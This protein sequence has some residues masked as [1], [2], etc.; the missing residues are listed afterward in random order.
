MVNGNVQEFFKVWSVQPSQSFL[1]SLLPWLEERFEAATYMRNPSEEGCILFY[2]CPVMGVISALKYS[3][4]LSL[5]TT[6]L[7]SRPVNGIAVIVHPN[8]ASEGRRIFGSFEALQRVACMSASGMFW[9]QFTV[10]LPCAAQGKRR[11]M[12]PSLTRTMMRKRRKLV[13]WMTQGTM[14]QSF[15]LT[16]GTDSRPI[17]EH[18]TAT[19]W[20]RT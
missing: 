13:R 7:A 1:P 6:F 5:I 9:N 16:S 2:N 8:R 18:R 14:S 11:R 19:F 20:S 10:M 17:C 15:W 3:H 4:M 12:S